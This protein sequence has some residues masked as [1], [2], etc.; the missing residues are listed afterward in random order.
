MLLPRKKSLPQRPRL[1]PLRLRIPQRV[2]LRLSARRTDPQARDA[3]KRADL[4]VTAAD[5]PRV[6]VLRVTAAAV[7]ADL[8]AEQADPVR[9]PDVPVWAQGDL[10]AVREGP[11]AE[12]ADRRVREADSA[13]LHPEPLYRV[14]AAR[15]A[16][17]RRTAEVLRMPTVTAEAGI[18]RIKRT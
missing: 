8:Q 16:A 18:S 6:C 11:P 4:P 2:L 14:R 10:L 17:V 7:P 3:P 5:L 13:D 9:E 1:C 15:A 12:A